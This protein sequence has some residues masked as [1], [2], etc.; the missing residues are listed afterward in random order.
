[1]LFVCMYN[2]S[3]LM[4]CLLEIQHNIHCAKPSALNVYLSG[5]IRC[6]SYIALPSVPRGIRYVAARMFGVLAS[7]R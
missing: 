2:M 7:L 6:I 4:C 1:M 5:Y 3:I